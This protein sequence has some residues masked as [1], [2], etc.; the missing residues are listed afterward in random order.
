M[1][2]IIKF[3][4]SEAEDYKILLRNVPT[5]TIIFF[6]VATCFMNLLASKE[7]IAYKYIAL[8]C[9][10]LLSWI[11]FLTMDMMTKRFGAKAAIKI[12][13]FAI[14]TN[15]C[16]SILLALVSL[17]PSNWAAFYETGDATVNA[18]INMTIGNTWYIVLG[19]M[20]AFG[21]ASV[22]N[23]LMN[24]FIGNLF[25]KDNFKTYCIRSYVST[26]LGQFLDNL[27]FALFVSYNFFG[28][29]ITQCIMCSICGAVF[30]LV[31]EMVFSPFGYKMCKKW[32][33]EGLGNEYLEYKTR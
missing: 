23:C 14:V 7:F 20:L 9:G 31:A 21:I 17:V 5:V 18:A 29:T 27:I 4:K 8:D 15:I 10:F 26:A 12:S 25:K 1:N 30:E 11:S 3:F 24:E 13:V 2:S 6:T 32:E 33:K 19:S 22:F 16:F 28:W